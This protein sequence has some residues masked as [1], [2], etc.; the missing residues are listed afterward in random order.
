MRYT[1]TDRVKE[2]VAKS[3]KAERNMDIYKKYVEDGL[4]MREIGEEYGITTAR[5][6]VIYN[7][8]CSELEEDAPS[9][10]KYEINVHKDKE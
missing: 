8:L 6:S 5:V 7:R 9:V 4:S 10:D 2:R 3:T 1:M